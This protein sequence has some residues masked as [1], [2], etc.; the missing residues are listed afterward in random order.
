MNN[1][2][3]GLTNPTYLL[4]DD[5]KI[6]ASTNTEDLQH[7][8]YMFNKWSQS[9]DLPLNT[10][11]W[12]VLRVNNLKNRIRYPRSGTDREEITSVHQVR[13]LGIQV[14]RNFLPSAQFSKTAQKV[15]FELAQL[16]H[17]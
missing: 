17:I 3:A 12:I 5:E 14:Y 10:Q 16:P 9:L 7:D 1:L 11:T 15:S 8:F 4:A 2:T 6:V 13:N